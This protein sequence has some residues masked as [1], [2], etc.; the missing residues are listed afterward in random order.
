MLA[1]SHEKKLEL[2]PAIEWYL[3][4]IQTKINIISTLN[5]RDIASLFHIVAVCYDKLKDHLTAV[6]YKQKALEI[7]KE[8]Y[9]ENK[10]HPEIAKTL[11]SLALSYQKMGN[12]QLALDNDLEALKMRQEIYANVN[13]TSVSDSL[14]S[15]GT[16]YEKLDQLELAYQF[17]EKAYMMRREASSP[18]QADIAESLHCMAI[19][20]EKLKDYEKSV[21][22]DKVFIS[23]KN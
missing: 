12:P 5:D 2:K 11:Y 16:N 7:R 15:V 1:L 13:N 18:N 8:I 14:H 23:V 4:A 10:I 21:A 22:Y 20:S 17:Y 6:N 9:K 3:K 19:V